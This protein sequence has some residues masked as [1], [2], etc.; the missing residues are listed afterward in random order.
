MSRKLR[1]KE[2]P[3]PCKLCVGFET[4]L[5]GRDW[6]R[7]WRKFCLYKKDPKQYLHNIAILKGKSKSKCKDFKRKDASN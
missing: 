2:S 7:F 4:G 5:D 6:F 1:T 3:T